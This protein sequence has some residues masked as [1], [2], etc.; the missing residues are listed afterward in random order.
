MRKLYGLETANKIIEHQLCGD[1]YINDF[2][3]VGG[4]FS[5]CYNY[6]TY[7]IMTK[8]LPMIKKIK[9]EPP[10]YLFA[11]KSQLEQFTII[12]ANSTLGATGLADTLVVMSYYVKNC[13]NT[14]RDAHFKFDSEEDVWAYVKETIISL[15]YTLNQPMRGNQSCFTNISVYDNYFLDKLCND[16]IFP[17][18]TNPDKEIVKKLQEVFLDSMNEI[19]SRTPCTFPVTTACFSVDEDH[20]IKDEDFL[21]FIAEKNSAYGFINIY[22]GDSST[23][24]SCCFDG[25]TEVIYRS[26]MKCWPDEAL[27]GTIKECYDLYNDKYVFLLNNG[28]WVKGKPVKLN[29]VK[30]YKIILE[31]GYDITLTYNHINATNHGDIATENLTTDDKL[32]LDVRSCNMFGIDAGVPHYENGRLYI[33]I[34]DIKPLE[35][36]NKEYVYC[37][38]MEDENNPYFMLAN[39]ILTHNCR[40]RSETKSEYFNSFGS[41]S[42]K[43]GSL[44][45]CTINLPRLSIKHPDD[46]DFFNALEEMVDIC[47]KVNNAKRHIVK[48]RIKSGNEP[49]Y[50]LGFMDINTQYSSVGTIGYAEMLSYRGLDILT[51]EGVEF[52]LKA[53]EVINTTNDKLQKKY[54]APHNSEA[55]PGE[56]VAIKLTVKDHILGYQDD[57]DLYSNQFIPLI[58]NADMLDRIRLQG[59]FDSKFS[60]G[61]IMHLNIDTKI[62]NPDDL[63]TLIKFTAKNKVIYFAINYVLSKCENEHMSVTKDG[64]CPIC[65]AKITD[66]YTRVVGFLTNTKNWPKTRREI[67]YPNRTFYKNI[68]VN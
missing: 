50:D 3:G 11:F 33:G 10:K 34:K 23:L 18:G 4:G 48:K 39:G 52:M 47:G 37:F 15:I 9:S 32:V 35:V 31:N 36:Y 55:I 42:S 20:N 21:H 62:E 67:D 63:A 41:G 43:I 30:M 45:V 61:A 28:K 12:A 44:G 2:H 13:L 46:N 8:G 59:I 49:L 60:G 58:V 64:I 68:K 6:S 26:T 1:I 54:N 65:G 24:S 51:D 22:A 53:I 17:D 14:L 66:E 38:E 27:K 25:D 57:C 19:L 29:A 5:Y 16:Y 7:D 56:S 40:L